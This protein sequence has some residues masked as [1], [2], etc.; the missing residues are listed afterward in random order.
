MAKRLCSRASAGIAA[1]Q[2]LV[3]P[4]PESAILPT[5]PVGTLSFQHSHG[6]PMR[7]GAQQPRRDSFIHSGKMRPMTGAQET[8]SRSNRPGLE[9]SAASQPACIAMPQCRCRWISHADPWYGRIGIRPS[10]RGHGS[11]PTRGVGLRAPAHRRA[12]LARIGCNAT[13][14]KNRA[15]RPD[16]IRHSV[17]SWWCSLARCAT[18]SAYP[19]IGLS[20]FRKA[21]FV[22]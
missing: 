18:A 5:R 3:N 20:D 1:G 15:D 2:I 16:V 22:E 17:A 9:L 8:V 11:M 19:P 12:H 13:V 6:T 4:K 21:N 7:L 14:R 10:P